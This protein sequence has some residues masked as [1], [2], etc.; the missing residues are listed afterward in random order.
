MF[1]PLTGVLEVIVTAA[2]AVP[3]YEATGVVK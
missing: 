2:E 1:S 3:K